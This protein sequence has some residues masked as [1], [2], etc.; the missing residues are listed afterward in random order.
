MDNRVSFRVDEE[1]ARRL[2]AEARQRKTTMTAIIKEAIRE[3]WERLP[4][5]PSSRATTS[6]PKK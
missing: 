1:T 3:E 5:Q 6:S 4:K 2:H